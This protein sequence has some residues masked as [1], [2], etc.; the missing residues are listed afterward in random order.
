MLPWASLLVGVAMVAGLFIA[1]S[2][3]RYR[4]EHAATIGGIVGSL[5][6]TLGLSLPLAQF[7]GFS[8]ASGTL[9]ATGVVA[10]V[11]TFGGFGYAE[12]HRGSASS[13]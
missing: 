3:K 4:G 13:N 7:N 11:A 2:R 1:S 5:G 12:S 10:I 8:L 9:I 6:A